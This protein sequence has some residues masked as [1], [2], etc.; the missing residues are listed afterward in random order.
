[1]LAWGGSDELDIADRCYLGSVRVSLISESKLAS[2]ADITNL[3]A[4]I[5]LS[6]D[7]G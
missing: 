4:G 6:V 7:G 5:L 2:N 3:A 1:M